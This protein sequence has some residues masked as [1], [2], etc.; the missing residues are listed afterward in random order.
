M[1]E[2]ENLVAALTQMIAPRLFILSGDDPKTMGFPFAD[3]KDAF[4]VRMSRQFDPVTFWTEM[5][6]EISEAIV[7]VIYGD[8]KVPF[9]V[10]ELI[11]R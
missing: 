10:D 2:R 6:E 7:D 5:A 11:E 3:D 1:S 9:V 4:A 8:S